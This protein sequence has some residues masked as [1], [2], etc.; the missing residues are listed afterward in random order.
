MQRKKV[1][2]VFWEKISNRNS[3][4][5]SPHDPRDD[6]GI[7]IKDCN[8]LHYSREKEFGAWLSTIKQHA[9]NGINYTIY[10]LKYIT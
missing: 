5:C 8:V 10:L 2:P 1:T 3:S 4:Y 7:V 6:S 9:G